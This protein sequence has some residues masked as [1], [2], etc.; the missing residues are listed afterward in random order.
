MTME[1]HWRL[2][3]LY[4]TA[5]MKNPHHSQDIWGDRDG[6]SSSVLAEVGPYDI[7]S[8]PGDNDV[9]TYRFG[10]NYILCLVTHQDG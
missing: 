5:V 7:R 9:V 4:V 1:S 2:M 3:M 6:Q 8:Y 10:I